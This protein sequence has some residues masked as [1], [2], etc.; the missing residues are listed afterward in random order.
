MRTWIY[1]AALGTGVLLVALLGMRVATAFRARRALALRLAESTTELSAIRARLA[2]RVLP[3]FDGLTQ[4]GGDCVA[5]Q[6]AVMSRA[7][8]LEGEVLHR[9]SAAFPLNGAQIKFVDAHRKEDAALGDAA[10]KCDRIV[11]EPAAYPPYSSAWDDPMDADVRALMLLLDGRANAFAGDKETAGL[12]F[13]QSQR[14]GF[15]LCLDEDMLGTDAG[16]AVIGEAEDALAR[17]IAQGVSEALRDRTSRELS[18]LEPFLPDLPDT[19]RLNYADSA[20]AMAGAVLSVPFWADA[21]VPESGQ[22]FAPW[23]FGRGIA[24]L[25]LPRSTQ[26][27]ALLTRAKSETDAT[28]RVISELNPKAL[29]QLDSLEHSGTRGFYPL[30]VMAMAGRQGRKLL[31]A[32]SYSVLLRAVIDL[33]RTRASQ[34]RYPAVPKLPLDPYAPARPLG[35]ELLPDGEYLLSSVGDGDKPSLRWVIA[36][37]P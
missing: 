24:A 29:A 31:R 7:P 26:S 8:T 16:A 11:R 12:R 37:R 30:N 1:R 22:D 6:R 35:Y 27:S 4:G 5:A 2:T 15:E 17:L 33:A 10:T 18:A 32:A 28:L 3:A 23:S 20:T 13:L 34:G 21:L 25:A 9:S 14:L 19:L 36:S